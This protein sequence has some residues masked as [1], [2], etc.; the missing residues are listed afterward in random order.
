MC[1]YYGCDGA[2]V[3]NANL[4]PKA[5][6]IETFSKGMYIALAFGKISFSTRDTVYKSCR[7][8][9]VF[10]FMR[11]YDGICLGATPSCES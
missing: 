3:V 9:C 8:A 7:A 5:L 1:K 6:C 10:V 11:K 4:I 2:A